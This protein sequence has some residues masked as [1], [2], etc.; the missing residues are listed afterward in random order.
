[1]HSIEGNSTSLA[2]W[3]VL[4][5]FKHMIIQESLNLA[6]SDRILLW[7][8]LFDHKLQNQWF[9]WI[10]WQ[11][12]PISPNKEHAATSGIGKEATLQAL[13]L[14]LSLS[15]SLLL[16]DQFIA[17]FDKWARISHYQLCFIFLAK[18]FLIFLFWVL[19]MK[20]EHSSAYAC[21]HSTSIHIL[22]IVIIRLFFC[23][24]RSREWACFSHFSF[25][26]EA[27]HFVISC[28]LYRFASLLFISTC[29]LQNIPYCW[30]RLLLWTPN[31]YC[32]LLCDCFSFVF[33]FS[34]WILLKLRSIQNHLKL[35]VSY[36][37]ASKETLIF[38][39]RNYI[40]IS[41]FDILLRKSMNILLV[42]NAAFHFCE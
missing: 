5:S 16:R 22:L 19:S 34:F 21:V 33:R 15:L 12:Y 14:F 31:Q 13:A 10:S 32:F 18:F 35:H 2:S 28:R 37:W 3:K 20:I 6:L 38:M 39:F 30:H 8:D 17:I 42:Q 26:N 36:F 11:L 29:L 24:L 41:P 40:W 4:F 9:Y 23:L 1:M 27:V 7:G 25:G